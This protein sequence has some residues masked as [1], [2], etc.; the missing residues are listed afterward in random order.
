M[1]LPLEIID[2]IYTFDST[3]YQ[4]YKYCIDEL[5]QKERK[6]NI[7]FCFKVLS[8]GPNYIKPIYFKKGV[9]VYP[10]L[11]ILDRNH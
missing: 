4:K 10:F 7:I 8:D 6:Q 5:K 2:C 11:N 3:Y 1:K 9:N